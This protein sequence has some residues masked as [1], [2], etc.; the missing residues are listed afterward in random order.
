MGFLKQKQQQEE[1]PVASRTEIVEKFGYRIVVDKKF[2]ERVADWK[3]EYMELSKLE[4]Y[5]NKDQTTKTAYERLQDFL[6][7]YRNHNEGLHIAHIIYGCA[8]DAEHQWYS[9][10]IIQWEKLYPSGEGILLRALTWMSYKTRKYPKELAVKRAAELLRVDP[11][12]NWEKALKLLE[13]TKNT[14]YSKYSIS[15]DTDHQYVTNIEIFV[16]REF[17]PYSAIISDLS[18]TTRYVL[19]DWVAVLQGQQQ[20]YSRGPPTILGGAGGAV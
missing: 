12:Q 9:N 6:K 3:K 20:E 4:D 15:E 18:W 8:G 7:L 5:K 2:Y 17:M 19:P 16:R 13:T 14:S 11:E 10:M 1:K